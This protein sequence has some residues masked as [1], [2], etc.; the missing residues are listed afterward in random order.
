M[1]S[2]SLARHP[3]P[4]LPPAPAVPALKRSLKNQDFHHPHHMPYNPEDQ[5]SPERTL[6]VLTATLLILETR[7]AALSAVVI[8]ALEKLGYQ[9]LDY[10]D[11]RTFLTHLEKKRCRDFLAGIADEDPELASEMKRMIDKMP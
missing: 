3:V 11:I 6:K 1:L 2:V 10:P 7:H 9:P 8:D 5:D 4:T